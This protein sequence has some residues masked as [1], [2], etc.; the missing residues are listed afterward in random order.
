V[1]QSRENNIERLRRLIEVRADDIAPGTGVVICQE[2][3]ELALKD[4]PLPGN[5]EVVHFN[6]IRGLNRWSDVA[7]LMVVGRTLPSPRDAERIAG[8]LFGE[9]VEPIPI[10]GNV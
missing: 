8:V 1:G 9:E 10:K 3:V 6:A 5:I 7:L 4:G 2:A